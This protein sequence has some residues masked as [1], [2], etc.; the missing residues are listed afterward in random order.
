MAGHCAD[1]TA[2]AFVINDFLCT[3]DFVDDNGV[4]RAGMQT[5]GFFALGAGV[6]HRS[7][8][9]FK[10]EYFDARFC[11]VKQAFVF[12]RASHLTHETCLL[13]TSPSPR[14]S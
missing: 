9:V 11:R 4:G 1:F 10:L 3:S 7:F 2:D 8:A 5:P 13:Y 14:D 6:W 12:K